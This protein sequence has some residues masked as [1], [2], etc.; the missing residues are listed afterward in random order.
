MWLTTSMMYSLL[1][2]DEDIPL[3]MYTTS[4]KRACPEDFHTQGKDRATAEL[5]AL[6]EVVRKMPDGPQKTHFLKRVGYIASDKLFMGG[7]GYCS[8]LI[9][10]TCFSAFLG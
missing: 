9:L 7:G 8:V 2:Q 5:A 4:C 3:E 10:C 6:Y 1:T